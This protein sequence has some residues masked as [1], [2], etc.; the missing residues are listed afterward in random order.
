MTILSKLEKIHVDWHDFYQASRLTREITAEL[1]GDRVSLRQLIWAVGRDELLLGL[2]EKH[3]ELSY[4]VLYDATDRGLRIRLHRFTEGL[5]DIP[6]NHR[7]SFSSSI[8]GGSYVHT[9]Y[10]L[11]QSHRENDAG[12]ILKQPPGTHEGVSPESLH[13]VGVD[14]LLTTTQDSGSSY[15]LHH[16]TIHKTAMPV[17]NAFSIFIRGP[18]EK[19]CALQLQPDE[20]SYLWKFGRQHE[21]PTVISKRTMTLE[22]YQNF[23]NE[24]EE[25]RVI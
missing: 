18:A 2:C 1:A 11:N 19:A 17:E 7:F 23:V 6:H 16:T 14:P 25:E 13:I 21:D 4:I 5:E 3:H 22:D 12:W 15:S 24:L 8:I 20:E 9:L 10:Q